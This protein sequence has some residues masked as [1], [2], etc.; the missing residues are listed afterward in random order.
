MPS[1]STVVDIIDDDDGLRESLAFLLR[2][3]EMEVRSY[4]SAKAFLDALPGAPL[5]CV[6]SGFKRT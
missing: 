2:S 6:I 3:A 1:T 4:A 5:N